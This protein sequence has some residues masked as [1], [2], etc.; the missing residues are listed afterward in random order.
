MRAV[1]TNVLVRLIA[2]DHPGQV[3]SAESFV[4]SG[5]WVSHVVLVE[6]T[7]VLETV[8]GLKPAQIALGIGMLLE[9]KTLSL[10]DPSAVES[11]LEL[12]RRK[13]AL[14]YSDCL[15][16]ETARRAGHQPLGT[17]DKNLGRMA[18]AHKLAKD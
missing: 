12:Y 13:P 3:R 6:A 7:W 8:Y 1:D 4:A 14:G 18:G 16:L 17:F 5:A 15:I 9:H 10:Q 11:A 2:R